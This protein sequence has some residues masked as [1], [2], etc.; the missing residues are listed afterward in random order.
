MSLIETR[1][2]P[3]GSPFSLNSARIRRISVASK[4]MLCVSCAIVASDSVIDFAMTLRM[5]LS[6][7]T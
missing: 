3:N 2:S 4:E 7:S 6:G 1:D 5:W